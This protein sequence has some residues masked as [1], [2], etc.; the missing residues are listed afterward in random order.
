MIMLNRPKMKGRGALGDMT[1]VYVYQETLD[2]VLQEVD[3]LRA[4]LVEKEYKL[5]SL[6][7]KMKVDFDGDPLKGSYSV[8]LSHV[9]RPCNSIQT[10]IIK[11]LAEE[12]GLDL[13]K[14]RK[15]LNTI[16]DLILAMEKKEDYCEVDILF[17]KDSKPVE[18]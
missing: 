8:S 1:A 5:E 12:Y 15:Q 17:N 6:V 4:Q 18:C 2:R 7:D 10:S 3:T 14:E 11:A 13:Q 9:P 16:S